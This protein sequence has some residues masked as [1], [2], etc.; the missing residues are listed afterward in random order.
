MRLIVGVWVWLLFGG[1]CSVEQAITND[2]VSPDSPGKPRSPGHWEVSRDVDPIT[3]QKEILAGL[4]GAVV[5]NQAPLRDGEHSELSDFTTLM[6]SCGHD[7]LS[8]IVAAPQVDGLEPLY[9]IEQREVTLRFDSEVPKGEL[10]ES[11]L[12]GALLT[13]LTPRAFLERLAKGRTRRLLVRA[14]RE[15]I[16]WTA[17]FDLPQQAAP[18]AREILE[19]CRNPNR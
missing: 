11:G 8:V 17:R 16:Q 15:G 1:A 9:A 10:V 14:E 6:I 3:D 7:G 5:E 18:T 4:V 2:P 19:A 13:W 12:G